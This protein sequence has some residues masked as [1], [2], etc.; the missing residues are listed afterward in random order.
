MRFFAKTS[1]RFSMACLNTDAG[2]WKMKQIDLLKLQAA[3]VHETIE[4]LSDETHWKDMLARYKELKLY[5]RELLQSIE[6]YE[7]V[8]RLSYHRQTGIV[9]PNNIWKMLGPP[10]VLDED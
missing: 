7:N 6:R 5:S 4:E 9:T 2:R 8:I 3:R 10:T 1:L